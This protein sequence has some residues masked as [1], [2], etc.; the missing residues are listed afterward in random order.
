MS[1]ISEKMDYFTFE[2]D[3]ISFSYN[4]RIGD[5]FYV[6]DGG[7]YLQDG[8]LSINS[9]KQAELMEIL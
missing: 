6:E 8:K 7:K 4:D 1:K 5:L 2:V 9:L 3:S